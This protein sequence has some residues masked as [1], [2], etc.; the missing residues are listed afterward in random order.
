MPREPFEPCDTDYGYGTSVIDDL[1]I[2]KHIHTY[3][4]FCCPAVCL[5]IKKPIKKEW[6]KEIV[7]ENENENEKLWKYVQVLHARQAHRLNYFP[8]YRSIFLVVV[9]VVFHV[10]HNLLV[11]STLYPVGAQRACKVKHARLMTMWSTFCSLALILQGIL[12]LSFRKLYF[13][14]AHNYRIELFIFSLS[15]MLAAFSFC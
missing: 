3:R 8:I 1:H 11:I 13:L 10:V 2:H 5:L 7:N 12:E 6:K 15:F 4:H 14:C 9:V